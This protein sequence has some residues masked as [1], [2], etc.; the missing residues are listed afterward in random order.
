MELI[1]VG[2]VLM[3]FFV[4]AVGSFV[5]TNRYRETDEQKA[6]RFVRDYDIFK[7]VEQ[8]L[9]VIKAIKGFKTRNKISKIAKEQDCFII[10][11]EDLTEIVKKEF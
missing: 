1:M 9:K 3:M 5:V 6:E 4:F 7:D 10:D 11:G 2:F 8:A